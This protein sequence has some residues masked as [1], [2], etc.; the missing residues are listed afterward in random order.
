MKFITHNHIRYAYSP[1]FDKF[2]EVISMCEMRKVTNPHL[3][4]AL[5][6]KNEATTNH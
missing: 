2:F 6:S 4:Q 3:L 5:R 1:V